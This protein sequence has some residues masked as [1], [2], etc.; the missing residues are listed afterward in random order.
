MN[1]LIIQCNAAIAAGK[2]LYLTMKRWPKG[3]PQGQ[4]ISGNTY[5]FSPDKVRKWAKEQK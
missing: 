5:R 4:H 2:G 1:N 3:F